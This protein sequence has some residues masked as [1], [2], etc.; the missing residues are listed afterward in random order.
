MK[1]KTRKIV[2]NGWDTGK[3]VVLKSTFI[4]NMKKAGW[5]F[6][7]ACVENIVENKDEAYIEYKWVEKMEC[8]EYKI[9]RPSNTGLYI[10]LPDKARELVEKYGRRVDIEAD[11]EKLSI[12]W[13]K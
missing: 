7:V 8:G 11:G 2:S 5:K 6:P 10:Y 4:E 12:R 3:Y 1:M 9:I 13:K